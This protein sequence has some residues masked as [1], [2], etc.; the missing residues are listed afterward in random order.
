MVPSAEKRMADEKNPGSEGS[1]REGIKILPGEWRRRLAERQARDT[2]RVPPPSPPP[3]PPPVEDSVGAAADRAREALSEELE[4]L[5]SGI[6][7]LPPAPPKPSDPAPPATAAPPKPADPAPPPP[8]PGP[9]AHDLSELERRIEQRLAARLRNELETSM[10]QRLDAALAAA[11]RQLEQQAQAAEEETRER[12]LA[13]AGELR[14]SPAEQEKVI[15]EAR[16]VA[17]SEA[18]KR[19]RKTQK[20]V[21]RLVDARN[22]EHTERLA[23]SVEQQAQ[24]AEE[25]LHER[26]HLKAEETRAR[27]VAEVEEARR[28]LGA[29]AESARA[30]ISG[31]AEQRV[32]SLAEHERQAAERLSAKAVRR[33]RL[34]ERDER[35]RTTKR[36]LEAGKWLMEAGQSADRVSREA[37]ERIGRRAEEALAA[38]R[39]EGVRQSA[40]AV[41]QI[42]VA[43]ER[44]AD[45]AERNRT[46]AQS[47]MREDLERMLDDL[48]RDI[49][50]IGGK[51][52]QG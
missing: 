12:L 25:E 38:L 49:R 23:R 16:R 1:G 40:E 31:E 35:G 13:K 28:A 8:A 20:K 39:Q 50:A 14:S 42:Q 44:L 10:Q 15:A 30:A 3:S 52:D 9:P 2:T 34:L 27:I 45:A 22:E 5:R 19:G 26:L 32:E 11:V 46:L 4:R 21:A 17:R 7:V 6:G 29:E 33:E 48:L 43:Q 41:A 37:E 24:A 18:K 51:P 47:T 36:L